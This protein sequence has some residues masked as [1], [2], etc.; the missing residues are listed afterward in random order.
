MIC[1]NVQGVFMKLNIPT[2]RLVVDV[3]KRLHAKVK[4]AAF[5]K[6]MTIRQ[7]ILIAIYAMLARDEQQS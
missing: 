5:Q 3:T 7:F 6:D 2:K 4:H 1:T